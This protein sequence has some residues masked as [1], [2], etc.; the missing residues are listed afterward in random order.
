MAVHYHKLQK[1][2]IKNKQKKKCIKVYI[3]NAKPLSD[4]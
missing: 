2:D 1:F 3:L 4:K